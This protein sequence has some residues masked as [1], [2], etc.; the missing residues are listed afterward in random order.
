MSE[1]ERVGRRE[2]STCWARECLQP[3]GLWSLPS[4]HGPWLSMRHCLT[5]FDVLQ[6]CS[7]AMVL[8]TRAVGVAVQPQSLARLHAR[9]QVA[10]VPSPAAQLF[11]CLLRLPLLTFP[12]LTACDSSSKGALLASQHCLLMPSSGELLRLVDSCVILGA[13]CL[14]VKITNEQRSHRRLC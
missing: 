5:L 14:E 11:L 6:S 1:K 3:A 8:L 2:E 12:V 4:C 7:A 13:A 9:G 10:W